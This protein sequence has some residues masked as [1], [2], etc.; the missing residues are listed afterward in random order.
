M[1]GVTE[2]KNQNLAP[3]DFCFQC[4]TSGSQNTTIF[5]TDIWRK[6]YLPRKFSR[7]MRGWVAMGRR[8]AAV[9]WTQGK[10]GTHSAW[11]GKWKAVLV[12][13]HLPYQ[14][15]AEVAFGMLP[16]GRSSILNSCIAWPFGPHSS[17]LEIRHFLYT[18]KKSC[19]N[20]NVVLF[21]RYGIS[22]WQS[23]D[24]A[25]FFLTIM[26]FSWL[27]IMIFLVFLLK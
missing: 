19:L 18:G 26:V 9:T 8:L 4:C 7:K 10:G 24:W 3:S 11:T 2:K 23:W 6:L 16:S 22:K 15:G 13:Q 12:L 20:H 27:Y 25:Q 5:P 21:R 17:T 14:E 1:Y